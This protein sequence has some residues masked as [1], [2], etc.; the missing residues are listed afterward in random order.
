MVAYLG[1]VA[2]MIAVGT[3]AAVEIGAVHRAA[4]AL[5]T[6]E[7]LTILLLAECFRPIYL[8]SCGICTLTRTGI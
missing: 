4:G 7:L 5:S 8:R 3:A 1:V 6:T 2:L